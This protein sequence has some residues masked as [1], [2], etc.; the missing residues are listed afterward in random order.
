MQVAARRLF[1]QDVWSHETVEFL[2]RCAERI[3]TDDSNIQKA[4][5]S[6]EFLPD[7]RSKSSVTG[8]SPCVVADDHAYITS[9]ESRNFDPNAQ[10]SSS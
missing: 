6:D 4:Q 3:G 8:Q 7:A 10:I 1:L 9:T 2:F 5:K